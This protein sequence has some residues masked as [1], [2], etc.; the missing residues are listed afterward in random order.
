MSFAPQPAESDTVVGAILEGIPEDETKNPDAA[1][2][3]GGGGGNGDNGAAAAA[4][5]AAASASNDKRG[6]LTAEQDRAVEMAVR[7]AMLEVASETK[8]ERKKRLEGEYQALDPKGRKAFK[9]RLRA[10]KEA[11]ES[12]KMAEIEALPEEERAAVSFPFERRVGAGCC[13]SCAASSKREEN[14]VRVLIWCP[15]LADNPNLLVFLVP[16]L[17]PRNRTREP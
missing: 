15:S 17:F 1:A 16:A 13:V 4:A 14:A 8:R 12:A 11:A 6:S 10:E 5:A 7:S 3:S 9:K 2:A